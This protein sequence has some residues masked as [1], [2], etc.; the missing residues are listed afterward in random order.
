MWGMGI[1]NTQRDRE[2]GKIKRSCHRTEHMCKAYR[3]YMK[4]IMA[5][6]KS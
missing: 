2:K 4:K 1:N 6:T 3:E 5:E